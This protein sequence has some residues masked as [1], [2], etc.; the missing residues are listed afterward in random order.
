MGNDYQPIR[1][2]YCPG[3][4]N[5]TSDLLSPPGYWQSPCGDTD[6]EFRGQTQRYVTIL[7]P[8]HLNQSEPSVWGHRPMGAEHQEPAFRDQYI[9]PPTASVLGGVYLKSAP[10]RKWK[11]TDIL[12]KIQPRFC[13]SPP[14]HGLRLSFCVLRCRHVGHTFPP[15]HPELLSWNRN[16]FR[17]RPD[18]DIM[19]PH[20]SASCVLT[21]GRGGW[22]LI[23][24]PEQRFPASHSPPLVSSQGFKTKLKQTNPISD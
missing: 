23:S 24:A 12:I 19:S 10:V 20:V 21:P 8:Q 1:D 15:S 13:F 3:L 2:Q 22:Q 14:L 16:E 9:E 11:D 5:Q 7:G 17:P 18:S 4:T 6:P